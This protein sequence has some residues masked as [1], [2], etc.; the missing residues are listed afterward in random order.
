MG[1]EPG[2]RNPEPQ[3]LNPELQICNLKPSTQN[4]KPEALNQDTQIM[5]DFKIKHKEADEW[6]KVLKTLNPNLKIFS[7]QNL[8]TKIA[9][10]LTLSSN[11][12]AIV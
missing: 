5:M 1:P 8:A 2:T 3:S 6:G 9:A 11:S 7:F 4:S 10:H 12:K